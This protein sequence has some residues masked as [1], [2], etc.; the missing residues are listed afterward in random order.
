MRYR[1]VAAA[2]IIAAIGLAAVLAAPWYSGQVDF[3]GREV[4]LEINAWQAFDWEDVAVVGLA[5]VAAVGL[6][7]SQS[8]VASG[9]LVG[10]GAGMIALGLIVYRV[11]EQPH[12]TGGGEATTEW[13]A[14]VAL[15][16]AAMLVL[17]S[18]V[19]HIEERK[20]PSAAAAIP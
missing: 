18:L 13:G 2:G 12:E 3:F 16:A 6:L 10:L 7:V 1:V 5:A 4:K 14:Y 19:A 15:G 20:A 17:T 9:A 8:V 11:L